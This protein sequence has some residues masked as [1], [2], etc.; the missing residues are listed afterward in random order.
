MRAEP[1][2]KAPS[3]LQVGQ[4]RKT[5]L[6]KHIYLSIQHDQTTLMREKK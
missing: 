1:V 3:F 4:R 5:L 2:G 6:L